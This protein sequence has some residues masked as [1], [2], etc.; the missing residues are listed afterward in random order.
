[1]SIDAQRF[2]RTPASWGH[3]GD[4][5]PGALMQYQVALSRG[6]WAR[7]RRRLVALADERDNLLAI[8]VRSTLHGVLDGA[9]VRI[10]AIGEP[11]EC[12][13]ERGH[14]ARLVEGLLEEAAD[15]GFALAMVQGERGQ[16]GTAHRAHP[17]AAWRR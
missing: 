17:A 15:D 6:P 13:P 3:T 4:L 11:A 10:C 5:A 12:A 9:P 7:T 16:L 1:V 2:A 14:T 8:A